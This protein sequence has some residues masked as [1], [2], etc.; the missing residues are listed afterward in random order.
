VGEGEDDLVP[1]AAE[2]FVRALVGVNGGD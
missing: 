2:E 1:F